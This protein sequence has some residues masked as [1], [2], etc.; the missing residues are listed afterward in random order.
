MPDSFRPVTGR[1]AIAAFEK[2]GFSV[3]RVKGSHH[4][5][6]KP[7]YRYILT[8]PVHGSRALAT[9]TLLSLIKDAG[10]S[11]EEFYTLVR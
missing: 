8:V 2:A 4:I 11:R 5:M 3:R 7:G 10:L 6:S 1:E 9:G